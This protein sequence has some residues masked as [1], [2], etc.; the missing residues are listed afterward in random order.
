MIAVIP[1][2]NFDPVA[3]RIPTPFGGLPIRWYALAYIAGLLIGFWG[4]RRLVRRPPAVATTAQ[5]EDFLT[6][7]TL[8]VVLGGRLGYVLFYQAGT[9]FSH[10]LAILQVW[11]GG[12]S[13]HGGLLGVCIATSIFCY[14]NKIPLLGFADRLSIVVPVGLG[15]GRCANFINGELWGRPAPYDLPWAMTFPNAGDMIPRHPSQLYQALLEGLLLFLLVFGVSRLR[16]V[17]F[18]PGLLTGVFLAGY[19]CARI[20]GEFFRQPDAF[21]ANH[22]FLWAGATMGQ[23][24]SVPMLLAGLFLIAR[25]VNIGAVAMPASGDHD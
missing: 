14:R 15:L 23:L 20:T 21:L 9:Y 1:F 18:R 6:W 3:F 24:L 7:A 4:L 22:G 11:T 10:P 8:G 13:F 17:F 25:A 2:P 19:A 5:V 16:G 12:M